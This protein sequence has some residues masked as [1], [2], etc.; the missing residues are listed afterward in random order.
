[1]ANRKNEARKR[2]KQ[3]YENILLEVQCIVMQGLVQYRGSRNGEKKNK[4][5]I[6]VRFMPSGY[7]EEMIINIIQC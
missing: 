5:I 1:M 3:C 7:E 6:K 4:Y 2:R